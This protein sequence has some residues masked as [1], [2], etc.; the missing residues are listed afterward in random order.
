MVTDSPAGPVETVPFSR[1]GAFVR[2]FT[3]DV[4]NGLNALDLQSAFL[5]ELVTDPEAA[6]EVKK[7]RGIVTSLACLLSTVS[8]Q[9]QIGAPTLIRYQSA[10]FLEDFRERLTRVD[11]EGAAAIAW[12]VD[13][14]DE[15]ISVDV[16]QIFEAL[17]ELLHNARQFQETEEAG[18]ARVRCRAAIVV[19]QFQI[20]LI[21]N[22]TA[23]PAEAEN[24]GREPLSSARRGGYG[25]GLF[26]ARQIFL[27]HGGT[28]RFDA[29]TPG[30]V[31]TIVTIPLSPSDDAP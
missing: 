13:L 1:V 10:I 4:R 12:E 15:E 2:Q 5:A 27:H 28:L 6:G 18:A 26:R 31:R 3:H 16:E 14:A 21:E 23:T 22:K 24:W 25:L 20:E 8:G 9:F 7:L 11:P 19:G 30:Q 17:Q 29:A